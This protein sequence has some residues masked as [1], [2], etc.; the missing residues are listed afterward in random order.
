[1]GQLDRQPDGGAR[2]DRGQVM[3]SYRAHRRRT[4]SLFDL[5]AADAYYERPIPLRHPVVFYE[6]HIPA[7]AVNCFLKKGLGHPGIDPAFEVLFARGI[8]PGDQAAADAS[9]IGSWPSRAEVQDY[10]R[11]VD[12]AVLEALETAP[13]ASDANPVLRRGQG[14]YTMLEH[15]VLHQETLLYMWHRFDVAR[16]TRPAAADASAAAPAP[17]PHAAP[18]GEAAMVRVA[19]GR[20]TL[21]AHRDGVPFGWDNEFPRC[22]VDVAAFEIG[23]HNVTNR[24]YLAFVEAGGYAA[25]DLWSPGAW[26]RQRAARRDHPLFWERAGAGWRWRGFFETLPLPPD[27]PVFV[28]HD[29]AAAYARWRGLRLPTEAEFHRAAYGAPDGSERA[30]PWGAAAPDAT[31]GNFG[32]RHWDP[33]P[34]GSYPAGASA[35][36]VH[37]LVGNGWEWT[38]TPFEGF[39]GFETMASYPEYSADFFDGDHYVIKGAS[40]ATGRDLIRRSFRNWFR[41]GYPYVY[42]AFRCVREVG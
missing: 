29:E 22:V 30:H 34:V 9:A 5:L 36:G 16:K 2:L 28:T 12:A 15:E 33:V 21:G 40:P 37:D 18:A 31:R 25:R 6:G 17:A 10:G 35:W 32:F 20:A 7:F 26:E 38:S 4:R 11:R 24:D 8:D 1:M 39:P 19:A 27:W 42:A 13:V 3:A 41:P 23:V 14:M